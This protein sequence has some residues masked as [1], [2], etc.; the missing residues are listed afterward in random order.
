[1]KFFQGRESRKVALL[2]L[3]KAVLFFVLLNYFF[4]GYTGM[5]IP[6]GR[7]YFPFLAEHADLVSLYRTFLLWGGAQFASL[8]GYPSY[9]FDYYL[10]V[11]EGSGVQL[12][13]SCLGLDLISAYTALVLAWPA[14]TLDKVIGSMV[15]I[16]AII[17]FNMVRLGGLVVLYTTENYGLFNFI[18][19]H[20][21]F[22]VIMLVVVFAMFAVHVNYTE[23]KEHTDI[24]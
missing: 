15:G 10:V 18:D 17:L 3:L 5:T 14:K 9:Y 24:K 19:H 6:G 20:D 11:R 13:Y 12:V 8:L 2:F 1:M 23:H 16:A 7:L 22:N 4:I 21:L